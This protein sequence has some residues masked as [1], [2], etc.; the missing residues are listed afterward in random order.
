MGVVESGGVIFG[1]WVWVVYL[2]WFIA[3]IYCIRCW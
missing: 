3:Y 2:R 1:V